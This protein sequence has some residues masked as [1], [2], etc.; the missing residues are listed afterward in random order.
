MGIADDI[1]CLAI[2]QSQK[3]VDEASDGVRTK[4]GGDKTDAQGPAGIAVVMKRLNEPPERLGVLAVPALEFGEEATAQ[5]GKRAKIAKK[6][7]IARK[8]KVQVSQTESRRELRSLP[9]EVGVEKTMRE[10]NPSRH[11]D[12]SK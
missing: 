9:L 2:A 12:R 8:A 6:E 5:S 10:T 4:I 1:K 3:R 7:L 11:P